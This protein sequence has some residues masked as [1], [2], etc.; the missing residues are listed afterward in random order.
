M[1]KNLQ[2]FFCLLAFFCCVLTPKPVLNGAKSGITLILYTIVPTFFP[3]LLLSEYMNQ[4]QISARL[5]ALL[6]PVIGRLFSCSGPG[7]YCIFMGFLCGYPMGAISV[8]HNYKQGLL[9]RSQAHY[10]LSFCNNA[11]PMF[12]SGFLLTGCF[13]EW[14]GSPH[15]FL[16]CFYL[17]PVLVSIGARFLFHSRYVYEKMD[18]TVFADTY[19]GM[20]KML[21]HTFLTLLRLSGYVLL[22]SI[23]SSVCS[24]VLA[25]FPNIACLLASFAEI[26]SGI[27]QLSHAAFSLTLRFSLACAFTL[28]GGL[29]CLFQTMSVLEDT[30]LS[31]I[32][33][34]LGKITQAIL[35]FAIACFFTMR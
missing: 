17:P 26:T 13:P 27:A 33:Y 18:C 34:L 23:L 28:F 6:S 14:N 31:I 20:D 32:P 19:A 3:F 35:G 29:S 16:C 8:V 4:K 12:L 2:L 21:F 9:S 7:A 22:F 24:H 10:L 30:D 11:S 1:K 5:G 25:S 15:L